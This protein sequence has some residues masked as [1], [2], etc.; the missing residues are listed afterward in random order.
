MSDDVVTQEAKKR[1]PASVTASLV[2]A[3]FVGPIVLAWWLAVANPP[4]EQ[5]DL[6]NRG[7]LIQPPLDIHSDAALSP[8][9]AIELAPGEWATLYFS[10]DNCGQACQASLT[11]LDTIRSVLGH[12]G[13]RVKVVAVLDETA[14]EPHGLTIVDSAARA[15]I[16]A[17][18]D[19]YVADD[20]A[21][22]GVVFL[23][24]RG[25]IMLHFA[26]IGAPADVK[27]DLKR[28]LR[29]SKIK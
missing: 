9:R 12:D 14:S 13:T 19:H 5:L 3:M 18:V 11:M 27:K 10:A 7:T 17:A 15:R 23:D 16:S 25:Q 22:S 28:L 24:W 20:Q 21:G 6:L 26:D 4:A 8:L 2:I 29:A 1:L